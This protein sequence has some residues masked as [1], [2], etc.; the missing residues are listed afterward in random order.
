MNV[1]YLYGE[2]TVDTMI[3]PRLKLKSEVYANILDGKETEFKIEG[4][5]NPME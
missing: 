3:Y 5:E 2:N 4:E 1:Y